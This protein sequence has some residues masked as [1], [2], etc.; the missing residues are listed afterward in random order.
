MDTCSTL[1]VVF[2][3][4]GQKLAKT[5]ISFNYPQINKVTAIYLYNEVLI[6][7]LKL[8][9]EIYKHNDEARKKNI[10]SEVT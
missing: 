4:E 7:C 5:K 9:H 3:H 10:L 2:I 1:F 6:S 8:Q